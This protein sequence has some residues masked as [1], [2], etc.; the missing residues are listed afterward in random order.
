MAREKNRSR[1]TTTDEAPAPS[2]ETN[3][4]ETVAAA[5]TVETAAQAPDLAALKARVVAQWANVKAAKEAVV[6]ATRVALAAEHDCAVAALAAEQVR[7]G[8]APKRA[9]QIE[10]EGVRRRT[11]LDTVSGRY[12]LDVAPSDPPVIY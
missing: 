11:Y 10:I 7:T 8:R 2:A 5:E 3:G 6:D 12:R 1:D 9:V 4:T